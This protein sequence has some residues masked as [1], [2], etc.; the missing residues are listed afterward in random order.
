MYVGALLNDS[1][2]LIIFC[3]FM[4]LILLLR[5]FTVI[6]NN[7]VCLCL[8]MV[9]GSAMLSLSAVTYHLLK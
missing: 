9:Q 5:Q 4:L 7:K 2:S 1:E 6:F 3:N 8:S